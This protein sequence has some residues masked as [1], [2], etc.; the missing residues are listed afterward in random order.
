MG[1][2]C[3]TIFPAEKFCVGGTKAKGKLGLIGSVEKLC[4]LPILTCALFSIAVY[5]RE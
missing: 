1:V 2:L 4:K 3:Q 5:N